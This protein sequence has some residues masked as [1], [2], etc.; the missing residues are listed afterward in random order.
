MRRWTKRIFAS[1]IVVLILAGITGATY[2][3]IASRRELAANPPP[4][5]LVDIGGYR[6]HIWCMGEGSPAVIL[7]P[8]LGGTLLDWGFVQPE[9]AKFTLCFCFYSA[10]MGFRDLG[11]TLSTTRRMPTVVRERLG[12]IGIREHVALVGASFGGY[13]M[14]IFAS[15]Y[16]DRSAGLVLVD[17]SHEDQGARYAAA[18]APEPRIWYA[19]AVPVAALLG[20][21]RLTGNSIGQSDN[22]PRSLRRYADVGFRTNAWRTVVDEY[23]HLGQS[24]AEV[25]AGRHKLK[26]PIV[27]LTAGNSHETPQAKAVWQE[28]QQDQASLSDL[29][30]QIREEHARHVMALDAPEIVVQGIR[31]V[32][33]AARSGGVKPVCQ[34][35]N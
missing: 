34:S 21:M 3:A 7:D 26:I 22:L 8:G 32:V 25:K 9:I 18:G 16:A 29:G 35:A 27:V 28:T 17:A 15:E 24:T 31:L 6:L 23:L 30:C 14:R 2:Q 19:R 1:L 13:N 33:D 4:G 10:R 11:P 20:I 12:R 5:E